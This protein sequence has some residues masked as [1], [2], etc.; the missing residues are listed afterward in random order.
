M[1]VFSL[2]NGVLKKKKARGAIVD[3]LAVTTRG[4]RTRKCIRTG[5]TNRGS[6]VCE[7]RG[8]GG[9]LWHGVEHPRLLHH[10]S[11]R[12]LLMYNLRRRLL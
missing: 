7:G 8:G 12:L 5:G 6:L 11:H 3:A 1:I 10:L 4:V 2:Y 9:V